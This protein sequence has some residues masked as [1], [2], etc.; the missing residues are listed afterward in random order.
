P[1]PA[2][3][4]EARDPREASPAGPPVSYVVIETAG[5]GTP[6]PASA[7]PPTRAEAEPEGWIPFRSSWQPSPQTWGPLAESWTQARTSGVPVPPAADSKGPV[8]GPSSRPA[9]VE[10][11]P[12]PAPMA[13][14]TPA[15][16]A[17]GPPA[18]PPLTLTWNP[19]ERHRALVP[20][21]WFNRL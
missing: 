11:A 14:A 2:P 7:P 19:P 17:A 20:L 21:V 16:T 12:E 13:A 18:S 6:E 4:A 9:V 5:P 3:P 8:A 15:A 10:S 1:A